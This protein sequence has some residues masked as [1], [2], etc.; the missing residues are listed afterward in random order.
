MNLKNRKDI[1]QKTFDKLNNFKIGNQTVFDNIMLFLHCY[2]KQIHDAEAQ[3]MEDDLNHK[4]Y[5]HKLLKS[6]ESPD[7]LLKLFNQF[8]FGMGRFPAAGG[9][10]KITPLGVILPFVKTKKVISVTVLYEKF[11]STSTHGLAS[12]QVLAAFNIFI[13]GN[14]MISKNVMSK[15]FHNISMQ[16]LSREDNIID[17]K[18]DTIEELNNSLRK[19]LKDKANQKMFC[20]FYTRTI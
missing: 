20:R 6:I 9:N 10:M 18:F 19:L 13:G 11:N 16:A 14:K 7:K 3:K 15:F 8:H 5:F 12:T 1:L 17:I 4:I 2:I